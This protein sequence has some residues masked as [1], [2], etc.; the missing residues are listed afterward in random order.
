MI[1][2]PLETIDG[3]SERLAYLGRS[4]QEYS[5]L[6]SSYT[7]L[8]KDESARVATIKSEKGD[9]AARR[10]VAEVVD[11]LRVQTG[12]LF[13]N[14]RY[15]VLAGISM[16]RFIGGRVYLMVKVNNLEHP[17]DPASRALH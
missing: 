5:D 13:L 9:E 15:Y 11:P 7:L 14:F 1:A 12:N 10:F 3:M 8:F 16:R 17:D 6:L 4:A 2:N